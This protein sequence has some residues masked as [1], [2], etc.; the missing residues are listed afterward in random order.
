MA[1]KCV[2]EHL[3]R[4]IKRVSDAGMLTDFYSSVSNRSNLASICN[5]SM[6]TYAERA[7][8]GLKDVTYSKPSAASDPQSTTGSK[9]STNLHYRDVTLP[10]PPAAPGLEN[11][12]IS[13]KI[14]RIRF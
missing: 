4:D 10:K 12:A 5:L 14:W 1:W 7:A 11:P 3:K 8:F 9:L 13:K 2:V 6:P